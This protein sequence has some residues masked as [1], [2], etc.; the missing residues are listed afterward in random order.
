MFGSAC[1]RLW[2]GERAK[3]GAPKREDLR[4]GLH[5]PSTSAFDRVGRNARVCGQ[6]RGG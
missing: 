4:R 3:G 1:A 5:T 6:R 2:L